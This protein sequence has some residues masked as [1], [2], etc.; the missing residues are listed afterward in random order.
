MKISLGHLDVEALV[1]SLGEYRTRDLGKAMGVDASPWERCVFLVL[2]DQGLVRQLGG[3]GR[4]MMVSGGFGWDR[5]LR[6]G[7]RER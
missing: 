3:L 4:W 6:S 1:A 5:Y 7:G 2:I